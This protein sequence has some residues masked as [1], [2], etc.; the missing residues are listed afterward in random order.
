MI[1][2]CSNVPTRD[3][4]DLLKRI[5]VKLILLAGDIFQLPSIEFGNWYALIRAFLDKHSL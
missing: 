4:A 1:D 3:M 2:E 5:S